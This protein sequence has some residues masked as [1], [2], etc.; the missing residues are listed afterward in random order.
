MPVRGCITVRGEQIGQLFQMTPYY[1]KTPRD[2]A[3]RLAARTELTTEIGSTFWST[4]GCDE[5]K[6]ASRL[7]PRGFL[8]QETEWAFRLQKE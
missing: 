1:W 2:G 3:Q 8:Y 6:K 5:L 7:W 4:A